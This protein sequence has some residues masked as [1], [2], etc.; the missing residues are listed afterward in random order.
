LAGGS[1][2]NALGGGRGIGVFDRARPPLQE[3][4]ALLDVQGANTRQQNP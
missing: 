4:G 1:Y 2:F 3:Q